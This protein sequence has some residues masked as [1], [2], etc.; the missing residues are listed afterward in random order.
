MELQPP[1]LK[2]Y[3]GLILIGVILPLAMT[4]AVVRVA[5]NAIPARLVVSI[6]VAAL[7]GMGF[8]LGFI[9][10]RR[11]CRIDNGGL[12]IT[13]AF[14]SL[15]VAIDDIEGVP[16]VSNI[17]RDRE[18]QPVSKT[19]GISLFGFHLGW[20]KLRN[21]EKCFMYVTGGS[22]VYLRTT[23][24]FSMLLNVRSPSAMITELQSRQL[25][26]GVR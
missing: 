18:R 11:S 7:A 1:G 9:A 12:H 24:G 10:L 17:K 22:A 21:G 14:Y 2:V 4:L 19:N 3:L 15:R 16:Q 26:R 5:G 6:V 8:I 25:Q 13:A 23:A 20:F